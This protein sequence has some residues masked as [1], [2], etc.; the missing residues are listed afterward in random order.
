LNFGPR[1]RKEFSRV[2]KTGEG[3]VPRQ[4]KEQRMDALC[5]SRV[6]EEREVGRVSPCNVR[7][8]EAEGREL[9]GGDEVCFC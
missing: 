5:A 8:R 2:R 7:K 3:S 4:M 6:A 9:V 1:R